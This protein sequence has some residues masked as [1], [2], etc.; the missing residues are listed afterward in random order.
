MS[1]HRQQLKQLVSFGAIGLGSFALDV[2]VTTALYDYLHFSPGLA[3]SVGF[4]SAFF[5]NFPL[6]RKHVFSHSQNDRFVLRV[7]VILYAT[8]STFNLV[9]TGVAMQFAVKHAHV[10]IGVARI[11]VVGVIAIWN[12]FILKFLIFSKREVTEVEGLLIQ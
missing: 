2:A 10:Q 1:K 5:F 9:M 12:F 4:L 7:Q 11:V 8:L 6:N 3:A